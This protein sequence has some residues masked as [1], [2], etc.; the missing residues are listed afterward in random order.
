MDLLNL[1]KEC[2]RTVIIES[3]ITDVIDPAGWHE[4]NN[5]SF[6]LDTLYYGEYKNTGTGAGTAGRVK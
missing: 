3:E 5:G 4:W 6:G 1:W 2:S